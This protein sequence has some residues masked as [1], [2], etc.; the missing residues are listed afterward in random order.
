MAPG[1][2]PEIP[3]SQLTSSQLTSIANGAA[4]AGP[5]S[6]RQ[7]FRIDEALTA[8]D[9]ETGLTFSVYVGGLEEPLRGSAETMLDALP[10]PEDSVLLAVSPN[11]R[12]LEIV[13]G[14]RAAKRIPDRACELAG[15]S[16]RAA[17][18]GGDLAG[19][20]VT[21]LRMLADRAGA[22]RSERR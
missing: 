22:A 7:L 20:I 1:D 8:A 3:A 14:Q 13:T 16:M 6:S 10:A 12:A 11:Q 17:F 9:R 19:G 21:G 5:F 15:M 2:S 4:A 18:Q